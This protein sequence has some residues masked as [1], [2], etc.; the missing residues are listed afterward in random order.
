MMS[1]DNSNPHHT[2]S[3]LPIS[4]LYSPEQLAAGGFDAGADLGRL[5]VVSFT[6]EAHHVCQI[7]R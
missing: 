7:D 6:E 1:T 3:G 5:G 4:L 2:L